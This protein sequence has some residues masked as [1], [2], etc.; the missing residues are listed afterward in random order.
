MWL[1]AQGE[2]L[3]GKPGQR[4]FGQ[5]EFRACVL[6]QLTKLVTPDRMRKN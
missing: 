4:G 5:H 2:H 1:S 3:S 6:V